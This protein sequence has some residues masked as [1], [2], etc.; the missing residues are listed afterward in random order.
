MHPHYIADQMGTCPIC[1]MDLVPVASGPAQPVADDPTGAPARAEVTISPETI[2]NM[3][4]RY[5]RAE[6]TRF[7]RRIRAYG[8]VVANE[9]RRGEVASRVA[10]WVEALA[11]TAVGD[12]VQRGQVLYR[13]FSPDLAAAQR[14]YLSAL[15]RNGAERSD[16]AADRLRALGVSTEFIDRLKQTRKVEE[17]VPFAAATAG[18]LAELRVREGAYVRPG[19]TLAVIQDYSSVWINAAVAEQDLA[20]ISHQPP[21]ATADLPAVT[22]RAPSRLLNIESA[23]PSSPSSPRA[24]SQRDLGALATEAG[25]KC[26]LTAIGPDTAVR[27]VLPNLPGQVIETKVDYIHP[28]V[29]PASRTGTVRLALD[30]P[31]GALRPGAYADVLFE[32]EAVQRL[33]VPDSALL[34]GAGGPYLVAALGDGRFQPRAVRTGLS[35]DGYTEIL[36]GAAAGDRVVVSGQF[37][38]DSESALRDSFRKLQRLKQT[39]ADLTLSAAQLAM[40]DHLVDAALYLHEALVDGYDVT[41]EQLQ[42]AREIRGLLWPRFGDTRLGP[43]LDAAEQAVGEAQ[44]A[45]TESTLTEAL[46]HLVSALR[47]WVLEGRTAHYRDKDVR[48]FRDPQRDRLWLQQGATPYNP[49]GS[50]KGEAVNGGGDGHE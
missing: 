22:R 3:G 15:A 43:L 40:M 19:E 5:G 35:A 21:T 7:G 18:T 29:D 2:Q 45:R 9:R 47:P 25:E 11:V 31:D 12:P 48:L 38:I 14:D 44:Q 34:L 37:L 36:E 33:A 28:T 23:M 10:G 16:S 50:A 1:G 4:V 26:R 17:R 8:V 49:Y 20:C 32:V 6:P 30:N 27:V 13:L 39:L 46:H 41:P 42:P 24:P